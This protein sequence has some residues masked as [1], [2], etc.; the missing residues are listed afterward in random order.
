MREQGLQGIRQGRRVRVVTTRPDPHAG[1]AP[2]LV[3]RDFTA[4]VPYELWV[5]DFTY[6]SRTYRTATV[7]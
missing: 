2:D 1:R 4:D 7:R 6:V 3:D 5:V